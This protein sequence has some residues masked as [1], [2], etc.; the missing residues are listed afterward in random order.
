VNG[1]REFSLVGFDL[2]LAHAVPVP[3]GGV[4]VPVATLAAI[5]VRKMVAWLDRPH[6]RRKDLGDLAH[7]LDKALDDF[8]DRRFEPPL[9]DADVEDQSAIF[10]GQA[11]A[12]IASSAHVAQVTRFLDEM[13]RSTWTATFAEEGGYLTNDPEAMAVRRLAVFRRALTG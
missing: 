1:D 5:V 4:E 3:L 8:D 13:K 2:A 10:V 6:E 11:V 9:A 12:A 7:V